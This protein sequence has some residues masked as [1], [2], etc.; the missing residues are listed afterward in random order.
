MH[1]VFSNECEK[2]I[3]KSLVLIY[4][5]GVIVVAAVAAATATIDANMLV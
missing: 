2:S 3:E 5:V 1:K 4:V